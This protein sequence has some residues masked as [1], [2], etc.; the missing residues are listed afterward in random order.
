M[1]EDFF[2]GELFETLS[3]VSLILGLAVMALGSATWLFQRIGQGHSS[4]VGPA[5]I[6]VGF[7][8]AGLPLLLPRFMSFVINV[9]SGPSGSQESQDDAGDDEPEPTPEPQ[10]SE[11][12]DLT[13][14][15]Y[16]GAL[17]VGLVAL[18]ALVYG[19][20]RI[21]TSAKRKREAQKK[22][23][24]EIAAR[25]VAAKG[26]HAEAI[27]TV[28]SYEIDVVKAIDYPAFND[29]SVPE[30][31]AMSKA[32]R[33]VQDIEFQV[34]KDSAI[35]GSDELLESYRDAVDEFV[36]A[37]EV[38]EAKAKQIRWKTIPAEEREDL[39]LAKKLLAQAEDPGNPENMRHNLYQRLKKVIDRLNES[40]GSTLVPTKTVGAIEEQTRL[41]IE[42]PGEGITADDLAQNESIQL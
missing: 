15:L 9:F 36:T 18:A 21:T 39:R 42:S 28:A 35:G 1:E 32:M 24:E 20:Y 37:V 17:L 3:S 27:A 19:I 12:P 6:A 31:S 11:P 10:P 30:V 2:E 38:A 14:M 34:D 26:R 4:S 33:R 5:L 7:L 23:Q 8:M 41:L 22:A 29:I 16:V 13:W 40:H 25:W